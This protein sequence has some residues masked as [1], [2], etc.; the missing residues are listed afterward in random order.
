MTEPRRDWRSIAELAG[1]AAVLV[2]LIFVGL[3]LRQ[4]TAA[5]A[6]ATL[7]DQTDATVN[8][9]NLIGSD[10]EITRIWLLAG[11]DP[12]QLTNIER[13]QIHFIVRGQW[14]R[15]QNAWLQWQRGTLD[16]IDWQTYE[17]FIC[18]VNVDGPK[19]QQAAALRVRTWDDHKHVFLPEFVEFVE[20][21]RAAN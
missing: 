9:V 17:G 1:A 6:A 4:N 8:F 16:D 2:G 5:V 13:Q 19:N 7:Q 11:S 20:S 18:R 21:C 15:F 12:E 10:P 14:F 3:E